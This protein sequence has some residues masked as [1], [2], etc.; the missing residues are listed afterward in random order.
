MPVGVADIREVI[1]PELL[2]NRQKKIKRQNLARI[3]EKSNG[4][5]IQSVMDQQP[6]NEEEPGEQR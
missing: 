2:Q 1:V 4:S 5:Q 6:P 3:Y